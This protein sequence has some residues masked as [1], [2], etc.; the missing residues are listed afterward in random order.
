M[1][2]RTGSALVQL[3]ACRTLGGKKSH[4]LNQCS[5][6]VNWTFRNKLRMEI[7]KFSFTKMLV[8]MSAILSRERWIKYFFVGDCSALVSFIG[9]DHEY[10]SNHQPFASTTSKI[11]RH[12]VVQQIKRHL[13]TENKNSLLWVIWLSAITGLIIGLRPANWRRSYKATP[14]LI[15]WTHT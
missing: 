8:K 7:Q 14:S 11:F 13:N 2:R 10:V 5:L 3:M 4:Y 6:I 9:R 12:G 15:G 1:R